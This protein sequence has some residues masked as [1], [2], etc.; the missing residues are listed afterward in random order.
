MPYRKKAQTEAQPILSKR[1][2]NTLQEAA[3]D[4]LYAVAGL[5]VT[6]LAQ[7]NPVYATPGRFGGI[8][9]KVYVEGDQ[10]AEYLELN[11]SIGEL[12]E[13]II[14]TLY[15]IKQ[16]AEY[17]KTFGAGRAGRASKAPRAG[18]ESKDTGKGGSDA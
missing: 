13:E 17:R 4:Q 12:V 3:E 2:N 7:G 1:R 16:V 9:F 15:D 8:Q 6:C 14:E 10:F 5:I 18:V 11:D